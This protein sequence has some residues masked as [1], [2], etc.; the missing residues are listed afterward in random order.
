MG[1]SG[2]GTQTFLL[3]SLDERIKV[4]VPVVMVAAHFFGGCAFESGMP[5]HKNGDTYQC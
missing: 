2:G 1:A 3:T 5:I 4:S